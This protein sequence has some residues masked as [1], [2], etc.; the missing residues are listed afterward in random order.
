MKLTSCL[1]VVVIGVDVRQHAYSCEM[2]TVPPINPIPGQVTFVGRVQRQLPARPIPGAGRP[3]PGILVSVTMAGSGVEQGGMV[4]VFPFGVNTACEASPVSESYLSQYPAGA[5]V[6]VA[7]RLVEQTAGDQG[8]QRQLVIWP[9]EFGAL[10]LVPEHVPRTAIG[11]LNFE[12]FRS[13][14]ETES[15][16]GDPGAWRNAQRYFFEDFEWIACLSIIENVTES[17]QREPALHDMAFY[18]RYD[19]WNPKVAR[20]LYSNLLKSVPLSMRARARLRHHFVEVHHA[21]YGTA[22]M[23]LFDYIEVFYNQRRR[24]STLGQI[25]PAAYERQAQAA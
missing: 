8:S 9:S 10:A 7:W 6:A 3:A 1:I 15:F 2:L 18:L 21:R 12:T 4:E 17:R 20:R 11:C 13:T 14:F 5:M 22:K 25:S 24:H 23:E 19:E 16:E